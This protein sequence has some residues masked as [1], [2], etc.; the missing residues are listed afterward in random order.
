MKTSSAV[1]V[2]I[3]G[4]VAAEI[5]VKWAAVE[6]ATR[7][8]PLHLLY[9]MEVV[10]SVLPDLSHP[11][12][13]LE[14]EK[15]VTAVLEKNADIARTAAGETLEVST[16]FTRG[17]VVP[18]LITASKDARLLV[19]GSRGRGALSRAFLGSV[20]S[21]L[22][23]HGL[24][25]VAVIHEKS[26]VT[27]SAKPVVVGVDG[28]KNSEPAIEYAMAAASRLGVPVRAVYAWYDFSGAIVPPLQWAE[29][30][31]E[32]K[33]VMAESMAGWQE[34]FP[35][36]KIERIVVPDNPARNLL[37]ESRDAQ[38]VV[39]GSRGRGGFVGALLGSTSQ[40][41]VHSVE[42]PIVVVRHSEDAAR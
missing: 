13:G 4:S 31:E 3:D 10:D 15:D 17:T 22:V 9:V 14:F 19:L 26:P 20:T 18:T 8:C 1:V 38:L 12:V 6:A 21:A 5:A 29:V 37:D 33:V 23:R 41:L 27:R 42:C 32:Q 25:P 36:V 24:C 16:E 2:G 11:F 39:V 7:G 28:S 34:Q 35:E 30:A 40:R